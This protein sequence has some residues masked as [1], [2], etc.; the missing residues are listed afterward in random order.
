MPWRSLLASI[1]PTVGLGVFPAPE[2]LKDLRCPGCMKT[3][4]VIKTGQPLYDD[5]P[6]GRIS[7]GGWLC[8]KRAHVPYAEMAEKIN[9]VVV[10]ERPGR[11]PL[12]IWTM[13]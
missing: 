1:A 9:L 6:D 4:G 3:G 12:E 2:L 10:V 11:H 5:P 8:M 13:Q 7:Q